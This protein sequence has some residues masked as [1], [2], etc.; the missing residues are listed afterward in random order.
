MHTEL[1]LEN[2]EEKKHL[3]LLD[4]G[5]GGNIKTGLK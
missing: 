1:W 2:M 3:K 4:A 5:G